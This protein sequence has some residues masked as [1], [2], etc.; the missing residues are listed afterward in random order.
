MD[1]AA[2]NLAPPPLPPRPRSTGAV[3]DIKTVIRS[4]A[5]KG[6]QYYAD[7]PAQTMKQRVADAEALKQR[8]MELE[9]EDITKAVQSTAAI[10]KLNYID[11]PAQSFKQRWAVAE[12][13]R[14]AFLKDMNDTGRSFTK[15]ESLCE[16]CSSLPVSSCWDDQPG[17][18]PERLEWSTPLERIMKNSS[19][20][21]F[22]RLLLDMLSRSEFD[23]LSDPRV[24]DRVPTAIKGLSM[25]ELKQ[26]SWSFIN[27][28][29]PFGRTNKPGNNATYM[30]DGMKAAII[31]EL[32]D[33]ANLFLGLQV[34]TQ[35]VGKKKSASKPKDSG[36]KTGPKKSDDDNSDMGNIMA[37]AVSFGGYS[38]RRKQTL[39]RRECTIRI[40]I[41]TSRSTKLPPGLL[42]VSCLAHLNRYEDSLQLL[43]KFRMRVEH[44]E[45]PSRL[46]DGDKVLN[47]GKRLDPNWIDL[48][49][50]KMWLW[51]CETK[52]GDD[53]CQQG[54]DIA[55]RA[56]R[57]LR[58][59]DVQK[60]CVVSIANPSACR[61]VALSYMWGGVK[62]LAFS[63]K[64]SEVL[65]QE[66]SLERLATEIP[67]TI[68]DAM[69]VVE[70][71]QE[72]YLWVDT[73]V[74]F[75]F[76]GNTS[77]LVLTI[78]AV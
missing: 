43:K 56:P 22:C 31:D 48:K 15:K 23:P 7:G 2:S 46:E 74:S 37:T 50:S 38:E 9:L 24:A 64:N 19:W 78:N 66:G 34:V 21:Q 33:P 47:Y 8:L 52:H 76:A 55:R 27:K 5:Q 39:Y 6:K 16:H 40:S 25:A 44:P 77:K 62:G 26:K 54:W 53:C 57:V 75:N 41:C 71:M 11:G 72:R 35:N 4:T 73:L 69:E 45:I 18:G 70:E 67:R 63:Y 10:G 30:F 13:Q 1:E 68:L 29:W 20:C 60:R 12:L 59:I 36:S 14:D 58:V 49:L 3:E 28:N 61:Y 65:M 42:L 51:E 32:T 17:P